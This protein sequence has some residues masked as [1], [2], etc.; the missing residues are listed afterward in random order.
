M[1]TTLTTTVKLYARFVLPPETRRAK[2]KVVDVYKFLNDLGWLQAPLTIFLC[3]K[4]N[5]EYDL[6]G[7]HTS[8]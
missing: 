3:L 5:T 6:G 7:S 8:L 2:A 1:D 4:V